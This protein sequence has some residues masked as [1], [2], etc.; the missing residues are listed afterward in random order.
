MSNGIIEIFSIFFEGL[1]ESYFFSRN[2]V[3]TDGSSKINELNSGN[4]FMD[5][6]FITF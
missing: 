5:L 1:K 6:F 2:F 3:D 4:I